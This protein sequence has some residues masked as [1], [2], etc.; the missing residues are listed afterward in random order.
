MK[1]AGTVLC[2]AAGLV[3]I[4]TAAV[5]V[6]EIYKYYHQDYTPIPR[7]IV[8]ESTDSKGRFVYT[9]YNCV[10]CNRPAQGFRNDTLGDN[11]DMNGDVGK[12][13]LAL[14]TTRDKAAGAPITADLIA[15]KGSNKFPADKSAT[16]SLFGQEDSLNIV[17]TEYCYNDNLNGLYIFSGT[18]MAEETPA[19]PAAQTVSEAETETETESTETGNEALSSD[20]TDNK[21]AAA[22]S[23][24][25][26]GTM[27]LS[28]VGSAAAGALICFLITRRKRE[29]TAA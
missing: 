22:G 26:T 27:F 9:A 5:T 13:W 20:S 17:S 4:G 2:I 21:A 14:Y 28:C 10:L 18:G 3:A 19:K 8:H 7:M 24:V 6:Y 23:V 16:V 15:Q 25:G 29:N 1:T 11:G 12:Q